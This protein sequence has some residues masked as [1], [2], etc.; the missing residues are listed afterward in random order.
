MSVDVLLRLWISHY[1]NGMLMV[2]DE[3]KVGT[4]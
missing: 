3:N 4:K 2:K 1:C